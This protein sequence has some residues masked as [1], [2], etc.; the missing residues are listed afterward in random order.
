MLAARKVPGVAEIR[1]TC[2]ESF[3]HRICLID[4]IQFRTYSISVLRG[5]GER[6]VTVGLRTCAPLVYG[7]VRRS[8]GAWVAFDGVVRNSQIPFS[9]TPGRGWSPRIRVSR[10]IAY[11]RVAGFEFLEATL[12][13][14]GLVVRRDAGIAVFRVLNFAQTFATCQALCLRPFRQ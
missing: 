2:Q 3:E 4:Q 1:R 6:C 10:R 11:E 12:Q 14:R 5:C 9:D 7:S 13:G 8:L